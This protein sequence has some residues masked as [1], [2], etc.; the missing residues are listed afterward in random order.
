LPDRDIP[1]LASLCLDPGLPFR[2]LVRDRYPLA[3]VNRALADLET[4]R[5]MRPLLVVAPELE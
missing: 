3:E 5:A 4:R 1:L 2:S